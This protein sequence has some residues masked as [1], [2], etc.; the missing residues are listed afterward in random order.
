MPAVLVL[1]SRGFS[2]ENAAR[3]SVGR[4]EH[5][6]TNVFLRDF[7]LE[8]V[9]EGLPLFGFIGRGLFQT[10]TSESSMELWEDPFLDEIMRS[11]QPFHEECLTHHVRGKSMMSRTPISQPHPLTIFSTLKNLM[12]FFR[13]NRVSNT[14]IVSLSLSNH[15]LAPQKLA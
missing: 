2:L 7:D 9:A 3:E 10:Q 1:G 8:V 12:L 5:V 6:S 4:Q 11:R 13:S 15:F 14:F